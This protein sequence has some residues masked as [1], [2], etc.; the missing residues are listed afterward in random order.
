MGSTSIEQDML[1]LKKALQNAM[2]KGSSAVCSPSI[3]VVF[4]QIRS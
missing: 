3:V 2:D 4:F 1:D